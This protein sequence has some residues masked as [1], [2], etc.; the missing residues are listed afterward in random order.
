M[1]NILDW[2]EY[3]EVVRIGRVTRNAHEVYIAALDAW[4]LFCHEGRVHCYFKLRHYYRGRT[5]V[6]DHDG[7]LRGV[8]GKLVV[9]QQYTEFGS[10]MIKLVSNHRVS[11]MCYDEKRH[12][13]IQLAANLDAARLL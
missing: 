9:V 13:A 7:L 3:P 12:F 4:Q 1:T 11:I 2:L 6:Y 5:A 8:D 10:R